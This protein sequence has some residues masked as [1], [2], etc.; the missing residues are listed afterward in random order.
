MVGEQPGTLGS[1]LLADAGIG[2]HESGI[3]RTFGEDGAEMVRQAKGDEEGVGR[4]SRAE[5]RGQHD[6]AHKAGDAR[7]QRPP[8]DREDAIYHSVNLPSVGAK[9]PTLNGLGLWATIAI[10]SDSG[11][12]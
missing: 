11:L 1:P 10:V 12:P 2:R 6:V 9:N 7:K 5:D 8:A 4:G 3:E